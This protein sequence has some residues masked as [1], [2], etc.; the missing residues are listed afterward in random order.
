MH[1]KDKKFTDFNEIR[2]EIENETNRIAGKNKGISS[3]PIN[4][5][6]HSPN[7]LNLTLIDLPGITKIPVGDE[8]PN[9]EV[10]VRNMIIE[11]IREENCLILAVSEANVDLA[12]SEA[13]KLAKEVDKNG[14]RT[15]GVLTKFDRIEDGAE[16]IGRKML[17]NKEIPLRLGYIGVVNRSQKEIENKKNIAK[18][19]EDERAFFM[20]NDRYSDFAN[21]SGIPYLQKMLNK[22]LGEHIRDKLPGLRDTVLKRTS[23]LE[24][25]IDDYEKSHPTDPD[26][27]KD[28]VAS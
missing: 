4:L 26:I 9:I 7:V 12:N 21:R 3:K 15:I 1:C 6:I 20:K 2:T 18:A 5:R 14:L 17:E 19:L 11:Y 27:I 16:D 10:L 13:L 25:E 23:A 8:P 22:T 24:K 28:V